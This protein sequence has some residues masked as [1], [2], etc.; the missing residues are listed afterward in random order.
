MNRPIAI[1]YEHPEWFK[2]LFAEL[3]RRDIPYDAI[4]VAQHS[5]GL[6]G[7]QVVTA[8]LGKDVRLRPRRRRL[9]QQVDSP[10][11]MLEDAVAVTGWLGERREHAQALGRR[12]S[13]SGSDERLVGKLDRTDAPFHVPKGAAIPKQELGPVRLVPGPQLE[14]VVVEAR[15]RRQRTR[16]PHQFERLRSASRARVN[17]RGGRT[18]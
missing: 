18:P 9:G 1:L 2:P 6:A 8:D 17:T 12:L 11:Q 16:S 3:E 7:E 13:I 14:G 4:D 5:F 10:V 15:G